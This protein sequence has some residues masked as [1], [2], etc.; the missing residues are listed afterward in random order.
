MNKKEVKKLAKY[1]MKRIGY[2]IATLFVLSLLTFFMMRALPGDPF[3]GERSLPDA[4]M[5]ALEA[6]YGLDKPV[7][8]QFLIY[9]KNALHG[10]FGVSMSFEG[11]EISDIIADAFPYSF[12][13]GIRSLIF[14]TIM[15]ILLGTLAAV[16]RESSWDTVSMLIAIIG[17][18]IPSF[19]IGAL[20]QY[21]FGVKL[22]WLPVTGW[23]TFKHTLL[24]SFALS[25]GS[26][27]TISRLMR[28][29]MLDV[30]GQDYIKTAKS[31]GLSQSKI[32]WKHA[33]RNA[34][35][36]VITV[37]GPIAAGVLTGTFVIENLFAIP[38]LGK[39]FVL[40]VQQQDYTLI[41]GTTLFY[42]AFLIIAC[43]IVDLL[44]GL[45]DPRVKLTGGKE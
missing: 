45:I 6:K 33:V 12:D 39:M 35:M 21:I 41:S 36:P 37:L 29:S 11:R 16:K 22:K 28:T 32:I 13:L 43:L 5:K 2:A 34:I 20:L 19:L 1:I 38:G 10:D 40:G 7:M 31:K 30:L 3:I 4:T 25:F 44:Y 9:M 24:P 27:A 14:A 17:V 23:K 15:G 42:G 26:I 18:S 8:E